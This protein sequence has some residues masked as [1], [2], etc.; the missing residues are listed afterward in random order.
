MTT[1][2]DW[3]HYLSTPSEIPSDDFRRMGSSHYMNS[4]LEPFLQDL[5]SCPYDDPEVFRQAK[6]E[7]PRFRVASAQDLQGFTRIANSNTLIRK[8]DRDFWTLVQGED[9]TFY[10]ERLCDDDGNPLLA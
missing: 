8:A 9:G 1:K 2:K 3:L 5:P 6:I 4:E 10:I 7:G